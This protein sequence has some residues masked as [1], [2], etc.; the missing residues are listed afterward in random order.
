MVGYLFGLCK[1]E[2]GCTDRQPIHVPSVSTPQGSVSMPS[3]PYSPLT[4]LRVEG[5]ESTTSQPKTE[6]SLR[7]PSLKGL[8]FK[9]SFSS[10]KALLATVEFKAA[11]SRL[12]SSYEDY[13]GW[14]N[15]EEF[16]VTNL[17]AKGKVSTVYLARYVGERSFVHLPDNWC[18]L[19][20]RRKP[21]ISS[22]PTK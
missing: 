9:G 14:L 6:V 5:R 21:V 7:S 3:N 15:G 13:D 2:L 8:S 11:F 1:S 16:N 18:L 22:R 10:P 4:R 12:H 19:K 20:V 17:I